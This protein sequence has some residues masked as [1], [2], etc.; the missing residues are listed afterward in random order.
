[1]FGEKFLKIASGGFCDHAKALPWFSAVQAF[2]V[3][4]L[5]MSQLWE[6]KRDLFRRI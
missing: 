1:M 4:R 6:G 5:Q 3:F 2:A